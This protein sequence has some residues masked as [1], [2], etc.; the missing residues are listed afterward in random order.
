MSYKFITK[1]YDPKNLNDE[2]NNEPSNL[3]MSND[4]KLIESLRNL[5]KEYLEI[6]SLKFDWILNKI[7]EIKH[8]F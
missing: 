5:V 4:E 6:V 1:N 8:F 2:Y 7:L 3:S